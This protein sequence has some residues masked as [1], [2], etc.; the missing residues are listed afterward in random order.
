MSE[1]NPEANTLPTSDRP[2]ETRPVSE[3]PPAVGPE[4]PAP[5]VGGRYCDLQ[6]HARGGLGEVLRAHDTELNRPVALKR[7]RP[8]YANDNDKR[9][10]FLAEAEITARLEHPAVVPV[11]SLIR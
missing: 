10:R 4:P 7:I 6:P 5:A 8:E 9:A 2:P 11:H 3:V 1:P